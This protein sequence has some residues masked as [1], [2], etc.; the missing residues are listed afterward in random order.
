MDSRHPEQRAIHAGHELPIALVLTMTNSPIPRWWDLVFNSGL[1]VPFITVMFLPGLAVGWYVAIFAAGLLVVCCS[2]IAAYRLANQYR[3]HRREISMSAAVDAVRQLSNLSAVPSLTSVC[4]LGFGGVLL[5]IGI[6]S[7]ACVFAVAA[8]NSEFVSASEIGIAFCLVVI[9]YTIR[10]TCIRRMMKMFRLRLS[11]GK[12][13]TCG[14][15][16]VDGPC[17]E[18]GDA[19]IP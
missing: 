9:L 6:C 8:R 14:Y 17:P 16:K 11:A 13:G 4:V 2:V 5:I 18:C 7:L 12:C 10:A 1:L 3:H 15:P 19:Y